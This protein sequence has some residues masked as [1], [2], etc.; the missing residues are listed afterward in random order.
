M[1]KY[2][3]LFPLLLSFYFLS[4]QR[5]FSKIDQFAF[6]YNPH[7]KDLTELTNGLT[8]SFET[9]TEK[10]RAIYSWIADNIKYDCKKYKNIIKKKGKK[11]TIRCHSQTE[12]EE[13]QAKIKADQLKTTIK[14]KKG[15][16]E[17]YSL[18]FQE[19]CQIAGIEAT[20]IVGHSRT[21]PKRV[22]KLPKIYSH[23]WN[24]IKIN[25]E[26]FFVDPTFGSGGS[27]A[28][29]KKFRKKFSTGYFMVSPRDMIKSHF[30]L[31]EKDQ[32]LEKPV[33]AK[34]FSQIPVVGNGYYNFH[35]SDYSPKNGIINAST[36][37]ITFKIKF[38]KEIDGNLVFLVGGKKQK[39]DFKH[40]DDGYI[41]FEYDLKKKRNKTM[42]IGVVKDSLLVYVLSYK[43]K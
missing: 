43:S 7:T 3:L 18:L 42:S 13:I 10:A 37:K 25:D 12:K 20:F 21:N 17:D 14:K 39:V 27:D 28:N 9:K 36:S 26:W 4:A 2:T 19:M 5:D 23:A 41:T 35:V 30:P 34:E 32:Y 16:C 8:A 24:A 33:S 11:E 22:G 40:T 38:D 31:N 6:D 29:C 1:K 15:V